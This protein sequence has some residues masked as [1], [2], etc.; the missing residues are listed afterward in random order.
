MGACACEDFPSFLQSLE[1]SEKRVLFVFL[2]NICRSPIAEACFKQVI[3]EKGVADKFHVD[4]AATSTYEIGDPP[5]RRGRA[6]MEKH[7]IYDNVKDHRALQIT[8]NDYKEYDFIFGMDKSNMSNLKRM[9]PSG[10]Y[11]AELMML[12]QFDNNA[13]AKNASVIEDPYYGG[14]EGFDI[15]YD[16][17][18]RCCERFYEEKCK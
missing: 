1:M 4:S 15:V 7:G 3:K 13:D 8:K 2:G 18:K 12:G 16:Q 5:D 11:K 17:C 9:A 10:S 14:D 6:C